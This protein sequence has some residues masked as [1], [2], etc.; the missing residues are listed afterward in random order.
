MRKT[1][2]ILLLSVLM[3]PSISQAET[4]S[5]EIN[6]N[7]DDIEGKVEAQFYIYE[8]PLHAGFGIIYS[9]KDY[10]L[11][12]LNFAL[13]SEIFISALTLGLGFKGVFGEADIA[14]KEFDVGVLSFLIQGEYDF[15]KDISNLPISICLSFSVAPDPLS[16]SDTERYYEFV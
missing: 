8:T 5:F 2:V 4:L 3:L 12:N 6:A 7:S 11:S 14:L 13:K 16:F 1:A 10:I 15:R 9:D